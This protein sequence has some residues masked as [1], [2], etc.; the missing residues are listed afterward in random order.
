MSKDF[1][2]I[3]HKAYLPNDTAKLRWVWSHGSLGPCRGYS[4][5]GL[6]YVIVLSD[7]IDK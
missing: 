2:K 6:G 1:T 7:S 5:R 3:A 4:F